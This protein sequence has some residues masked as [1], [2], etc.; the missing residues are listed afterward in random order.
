MLKEAENV[1]HSY[2][3][4]DTS[5]DFGYLRLR[6]LRGYYSSKARLE[7]LNIVTSNHHQTLIPLEPI[8]IRS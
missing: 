1:F 6:C 3:I 8:I 5:S 4:R 2:A 7:P